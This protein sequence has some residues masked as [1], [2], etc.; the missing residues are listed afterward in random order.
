MP[1]LR[2]AD[3]PAVPESA[4]PAGLLEQLPATTPAPPWHCRVRAVVWVQRAPSPL[5]LGAP[6]ADRA[7]DVTVGAL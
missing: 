5:A 3:L 2:L 1:D 7:R 4:L 6:F